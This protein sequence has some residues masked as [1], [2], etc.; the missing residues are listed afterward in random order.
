MKDFMLLG[1]TGLHGVKSPTAENPMRAT[2]CKSERSN[3]DG[4]YD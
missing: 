1:D 2:E 3:G 4:D